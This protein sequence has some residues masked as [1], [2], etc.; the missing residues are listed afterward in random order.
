MAATVL[1]LIGAA[2]PTGE[3]DEAFGS[4]LASA[5]ALNEE[6]AVRT[7][8][9]LPLVDGLQ[10]TDENRAIWSELAPR[11]LEKARRAHALRPGSVEAAAALANAYMFYASSLGILSAILQG[12]AGEYGEHA[13]RLI[14]LDPAHE[15][16]LGHYLLASY[17]LVAPWP[18]GDRDQALAHYR[19]AES[20]S[21]D[22]LR[23][24]YGL[25]V[26]FARE[27]EWERA[28]RHFE[29]VVREPCAGTSEE[30][31]CDWMKQEAARVLAEEGSR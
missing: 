3:G 8:G 13:R 10:D 18:F 22:S 1:M 21:P 16:G 27:G 7:N 24:Q 4:M 2:P 12:S 17:Y 25:G 31:F 29:R 6:M 20:V 23:N 9:N 19:S 11:A 26:Y 30:L 28:R 15:D 5:Q 14:A